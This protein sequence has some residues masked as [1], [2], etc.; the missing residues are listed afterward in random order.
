MDA[1]KGNMEDPETME[2]AII[3]TVSHAFRHYRDFGM[4]NE[5]QAASRSSRLAWQR[6]Q[7]RGKKLTQDVFARL[8]H[9]YNST[10]P[11]MT[12]EVSRS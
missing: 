7:H 4:Y 12:E 9:V 10:K 5:R 11:Q 8:Q 3:L 6:Q 1:R 2:T